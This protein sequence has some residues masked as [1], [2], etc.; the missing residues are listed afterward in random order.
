[1]SQVLAETDNDSL[2]SREEDDVDMRTMPSESLGNSSD[3]RVDGVSFEDRRVPPGRAFMLH[4][5]FDEMIESELDD[6]IDHV[7]RCSR[8]RR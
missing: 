2:N 4:T 3:I 5:S 7:V 1:M 8:R 6:I